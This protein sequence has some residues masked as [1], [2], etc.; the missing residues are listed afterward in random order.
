[1][2]IPNEAFGGKKGLSQ[3][4]WY[5]FHPPGNGLKLKLADAGCATRA[6]STPDACNTGVD[7]HERTIF[8]SRSTPSSPANQNLAE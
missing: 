3:S 1:M 4:V 5:D 8:D 6:R 7:N 2:I